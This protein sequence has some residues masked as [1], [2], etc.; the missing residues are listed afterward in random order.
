MSREFW[1]F[2]GALLL[3]VSAFHIVISTS[4]PAFGLVFDTEWKLY[5]DNVDRNQFYNKWQSL[6]AIFIVLL[7]GASQYFKYKKTNAKKFFKQLLIPFVVSVF[8][9]IPILIYY[10]FNASEL[11]LSILLFCAIFAI[12][13]NLDYWLRILKGKMNHAGASIA[14]FG[15][16]LLIVGSVISMGRQEIISRNTTHYVMAGISESLKEN[17]DMLIFRGDTVE[18]KDYYVYYGNE[19][20][21]ENYIYYYEVKYFEK[22]QR[23]FQEGDSVRHKGVVYVAL[24]NHEASDDFIADL[25]AKKWGFGGEHSDNEYFGFRKWTNTMPGAFKFENNPRVLLDLKSF[26]AN[27]PEPGT[28]HYL[29]YDIFTHVRLA[30]LDKQKYLEVSGATDEVDGYFQGFSFEGKIGDTMYIPGYVVLI[31]SIYPLPLEEKAGKGLMDEDLAVAVKLSLYEFREESNRGYTVEIVKALREEIEL[32]M[33]EEVKDLRMAFQLIDIEF[34]D[35][36]VE[37]EPGHEGHNHGPGEHGKT[38]HEN[39]GKDSISRVELTQEDSVMIETILSHPTMVDSISQRVR[40]NPYL[41]ARV[42]VDVREK[43]YII[44]KAII[45]PWINLLWLGIVVMMIGTVMAVVNRVKTNRRSN[46]K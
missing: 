7:L 18:M 30:K 23:Q 21:E 12:F 8:I 20:I 24:E 11:H 15:F 41:E 35:K 40:T 28:K 9:G 42:K 37:E 16:A 33:V 14:H 26:Q 2:I 27:F 44:M 17:E 13:A 39:H 29:S 45:F 38:N 32:P 36:P 43:E 10:E 19:F 4:L 25:N 6:F 46:G 5:G 22:V 34:G 1:M 31:D 3:L